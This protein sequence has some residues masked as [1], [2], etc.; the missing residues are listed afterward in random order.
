VNW[1][2][3]VRFKPYSCPQPAPTTCPTKKRGPQPCDPG[4]ESP[5]WSGAPL[6]LPQ[7]WSPCP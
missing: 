3:G 7:K 2:N 6:R 1:S 4:C 5:C